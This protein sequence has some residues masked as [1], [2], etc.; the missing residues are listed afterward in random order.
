VDMPDKPP[1]ETTILLLISEPL[2]RQVTREVLERAGY[3]VMSTGDL[4]TAVDRMDESKPDLLIIAPYVETITGHD[5][6]KYLQGRSPGLR[7][8]MVAGLLAD[9][10]LLNR[11]ELEQVAI[12]PEP[13][14]GRVLVAKVKQ[15]LNG[16]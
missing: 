7:I 8:L 3:A 16:G 2:A 11:A 4:G 1:M 9:D 12:F 14:T 5:A 10:R 6:A 13:F 15:V